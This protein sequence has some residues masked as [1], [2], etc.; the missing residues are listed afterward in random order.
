MPDPLVVVGIDLGTY[1]TGFGWL[2]LD[3]EHHDSA[4]ERSRPFFFT[5]WPGQPVPA[6]KNLSALLLG[7]DDKIL[8]WGYEAR[9]RALNH[10]SEFSGQQRYC[11]AFKMDLMGPRAPGNTGRAQNAEGDEEE[12]AASQAHD[13]ATEEAMAL[14]VS[15]QKE[16]RP[17]QSPSARTLPAAFEPRSEAEVLTT[18]LL[19]RVRKTAL[20]QITASGYLEEDLRWCVTVPAIY[21]D[22]HKQRVRDCA[23]EAGLP[24]HD[25]RLILA[26]EPEAAA[27]YARLS[28]ARPPGEEDQ[29]ARDLAAPGVQL[30]VLDCGGGT[31]DMAAYEND[32]NGHMVEIGVVNGA[33]HGSNELNRRFEDRLL[34]DR[35]GKP[36]LLARLREEVPEAVLDLSEAWERGKLSFGPDTE[37]PL[38]LPI[39][40]AIDRK[41]GAQVRKRLARQQRGVTDCILVSPE[42]MRDLF[43]TVVPDI[44]DLVDEQLTEMRRKGRPGAQEP[45][46]LMV[47]GFSNSPYL[48]HALKTHLGDRA[49]VLVPPDPSAAVL[50]GAVHFAHKPQTR[51]RR[52]RFTYGTE[53]TP[54]FDPDLDPEELRFLTSKGEAHC[55][56]RFARLVTIGELVDKEEGTRGAFIPIE[57]TQKALDFRLFTSRAE[58]PRY[59]TDPG[60]EEIGVVTVSLEKVMDQDLKKRGVILHLQ[61][62]ETEIKARAVVRESGEEA[63]TTVRFATDY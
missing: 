52:A 34:A 43:D 37:D 56:N 55:E 48:Q 26:L 4:D 10:V 6:V 40:S 51:A 41:L 14:A 57:G 15:L 33:Q 18:E 46:V 23:V 63:V 53:I 47:G 20:E 17:E 11:A 25:G 28:G 19:A 54:R 16:Q 36:E 2:P 38:A 45:V 60:C 32:E 58:H 5:Q 24:S 22:E 13:V 39:P 35:F 21:T 27:H 7:K 61:F 9:R 62:G 8:A 29:A 30:L 42:E 44:L 12:K 1:A 49:C 50:Y 3:H 59:V 31:V